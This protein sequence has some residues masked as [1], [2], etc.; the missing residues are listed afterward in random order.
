MERCHSLKKVAVV[1][2]TFQLRSHADNFV[3]RL[4]EGYWID[5]EYHRPPC[6]VAAL[7]VDQ[8]HRADV[9][10]K[11]SLAYDIPVFS[12]V[13]DAVTLGSDQLSVDGVLLILEHGEYPQNELYQKLY[14]RYEMMN[15]VVDVF[16]RSGRTAPIFVDKHL[17]YDRAKAQRMCEWSKDLKFP[18]MAGSSLPVTFRHPEL[19]FPPGQEMDEILV[20]GGSWFGESWLLHLMEILQTIAEQRAGGET[21]IRAIQVLTGVEIWRAAMEGR[22][23][24]SL[25]DAALARRL[26]QG[27]EG[28]PEDVSRQSVGCLIEY[29]D[30]LKATLLALGDGLVFDYLTAFRLRPG[31]EVLS[32]AFELPSESAD[33]MSPL[34][35][36]IIR[37]LET[38]QAQTPIE[39][40]LLA[41]GA[42]SYLMESGARGRKRLETPELDVRYQAPPHPYF[43]R[44]MG[45]AA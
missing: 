38:G 35:H 42:L 37:M 22:W 13:A 16:R 10:R 11:L 1:C 20:V 4:L 9:S 8:I 39:R 27:V 3:T 25:L 45:R 12:N 14:P 17:S 40:T 7:Y 5:Q 18:L 33:N 6:E 28:N 15:Q 31:G 26:N 41:T 36:L 23:D 24:R 43:A 19:D 2:S 34:V 21:G 29:R 30:G 32:T 44:R